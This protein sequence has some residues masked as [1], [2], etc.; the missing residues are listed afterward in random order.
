MPVRV[1]DSHKGFTYILKSKRAVKFNVNW[2]SGRLLG[3]GHLPMISGECKTYITCD[4]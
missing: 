2:V 4:V 3:R 1:V